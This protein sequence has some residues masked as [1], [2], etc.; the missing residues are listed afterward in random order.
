M[1]YQY[2]FVLP[3]EHSMF[4]I[5]DAMYARASAWEQENRQTIDFIIQVGDFEA[6]RKEADIKNI[7][8][9]AHYRKLGD[10][11]AYFNHEKKA[12]T[13]TFFV[14]GN[15]EDYDYLDSHYPEGFEVAPNINYLGRVGTKKFGA[16]TVG[17]L[18][19]IQRPDD[20]TNTNKA[21]IPRSNH[22]LHS[23][24]SR[25]AAIYFSQRD[26][27]VIQT[28]KIDI[29]VTHLFP[30][31]LLLAEQEN[32]IDQLLRVL[33]PDYHFS[34]HLHTPLNKDLEIEGKI[35]RARILA[36]VGTTGDYEVI[37][38]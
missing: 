37:E 5:L 29:L 30:R 35:V 22:R 34:G 32:A 20:L 4:H 19:G 3:V 16:M 31:S 6:I 13:P 1:Q 23:N 12:S 25:K 26:L 2:L 9:P 8:G 36:H 27:D 21:P 24:A 17:F 7:L 28:T 38:V 33:K 15:H 18:S 10:F 14:G 11:H